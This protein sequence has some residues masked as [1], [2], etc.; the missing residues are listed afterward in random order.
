MKDTPLYFHFPAREV[1]GTPHFTISPG[2]GREAP[3]QRVF[4][5]NPLPPTL[6]LA[7]IAPKR[8]AGNRGVTDA[9]PLANLPATGLP[10]T[11][12]E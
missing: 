4:P 5:A 11:P 7:S 6:D 10:T 12:A 9:T 8:F 2:L 1:K 3:L